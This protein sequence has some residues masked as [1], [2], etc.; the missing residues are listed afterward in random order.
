MSTTTVAARSTMTTTAA[1]IPT[2]HREGAVSSPFT[3]VL[4]APE[5]GLL[6]RPASLMRVGILMTAGALPVLSIPLYIFGL[7]PI[8]ASA[9][10]L[11]LPLVI[12]VLAM[13][14]HRSEESRWAVWGLVAGLIAVTAYDALRMPMVFTGIWPDFIPRLGGWII[15]DVPTNIPVG[16]AWR[17]VGD[18]G[19]IGMAFFVMC[20]VIGVWRFPALARRP[21][22]LGIGYG[23]FI[24]SGLVG[25]IALSARGAELLFPLSP[26]SL[27]LSFAGHLIYGSVLGLYLQRVLAKEHRWELA[28]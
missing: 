19:G 22:Q 7:L 14:L 23:I 6:R 3:R 26:Q 24:W 4:L 5:S 17:Y 18:G 27:G 28:A 8:S 13:T 10:F 1:S 12:I 20:G 11:V 9:R 15:G 21:I 2:Q 25:T 16:Y